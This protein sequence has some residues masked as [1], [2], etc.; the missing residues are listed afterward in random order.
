MAPAITAGEVNVDVERP[1]V[2]LPS[3]PSAARVPGT[4]PMIEILIQS[5]PAPG[6]SWA[7]QARAQWMTLLERTLDALYP[8][9]DGA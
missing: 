2:E 1:I 5:M 3:A 8:E 9:A 6:S 7:H 4:M